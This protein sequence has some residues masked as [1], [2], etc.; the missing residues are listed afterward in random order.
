MEISRGVYGLPYSGILANKLLEKRLA[1][2]GYQELPHTPGIF[3]HETRQV[4]FT[5][6]VENFGIK[7]VGEENSKHL[8]GFL[9]EFY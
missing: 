1:Q 5:L 2:Q 8:L 4:W 3:C 9:K 7:Y 6:V